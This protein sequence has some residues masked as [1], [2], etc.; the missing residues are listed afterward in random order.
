MKNVIIKSTR[1]FGFLTIT[2]SWLGLATIVLVH[3]P[4]LHEPISQYGIYRDTWLIFGI[5]ITTSALTWWLFSRNL[6]PYWHK[7]SLSTFIAGLL[8][9]TAGWI[10]YTPNAGTLVVDSHNI[11]IMF[12]TILYTLPMIFIGYRKSHFKIAK[13]SSTLFY[14]TMTLVLISIFA[15]FIDFGVIYFQTLALLPAQIWLLLVNLQLLK[16]SDPGES[17]LDKKF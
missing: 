16:N 17:L 6:N 5:G 14:I 3:S 1:Y 9:A 7:T 8:L 10:P 11:A 12:S 4:N 2:I 13:I 15:R